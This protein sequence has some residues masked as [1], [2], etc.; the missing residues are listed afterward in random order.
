[1]EDRE[2]LREVRKQMISQMEQKLHD[3]WVS[4]EMIAIITQYT[5]LKDLV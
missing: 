4:E 1:M 3:S 2:E 5:E